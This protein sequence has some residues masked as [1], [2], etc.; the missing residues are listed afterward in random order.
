MPSPR[1]PRHRPATKRAAAL[2]AVLLAACTT[3]APPPRREPE[4]PRPATLDV[5][6]EEEAYLLDPLAGYGGAGGEAGRRAVTAAHAALL[7][8][9]DVAAARRAA[10]ELLAADPG[11]APASV[12]IAQAD[13]L[14]NRWPAVV[15]R[16]LPLGDAQPTYT[17]SQLLLGRAAER[18]DDP[19]L[20][21]AAYRAVASRN[22]LA[23]ER[24]GVLHPKAVAVV[25]DR[26]RRELRA[27]DLEAARRQLVLLREWAPAELATLEAARDLA[28]ASGDR[29]AELAALRDLGRRERTRELL[30]RQA[31]LE[32][33]VGDPGTGL[34]LV[35]E[36]AAE[37][38]NDPEAAE[39]LASAK[40]RWRLSLLPP[41]VRAVA[42]KPEL[43]R[44]E[45]AVLLY[46]LVPDVRYGRPSSGRIATD[47]LD[48]PQREEIVRVV[49][50]G[51][52]D[53]DSTLHRFSPRAS[54]R[55]G[56]ALRSLSRLLTR[57]G[58]IA[59]LKEGGGGSSQGAI[60]A[61]AARCGI[62]PS[63]DECLAS[64]PLSGDAAV[65]MIRRTL[66]LL[67]GS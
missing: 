61:Q 19:A 1:S 18:V 10:E 67:G 36:I 5:A 4:R 34:A 37:D 8:E 43:D 56:T 26:L 25:S 63:E 20:A 55:R 31:D 38:P 28:V 60:C 50:L 53:V 48:H 13:H 23:F 21:Y 9:G 11:F 64:E 6:R 22:P 46:W 54:A 58:G 42:A 32:F 45:L 12:L 2:L 52:L 15:E 29:T 47:V 7:R 33:E 57:S 65:E 24:T 41:G 35:Q 66:A 62:V 49:N 3:A 39:R 17:A 30:E 16:L 59:C 44:A 27:N 14:E 51:L 40:F